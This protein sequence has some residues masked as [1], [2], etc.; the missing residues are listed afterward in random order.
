MRGMLFPS[1]SREHLPVAD[2]GLTGAI[3]LDE[4]TEADLALYAQDAET[5]GPD[6]L[7]WAE[8][9]RKINDLIARRSP[10]S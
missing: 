5:D 10:A 3:P 2:T 6:E 7:P 4:P 8:Q 9:N 1:T